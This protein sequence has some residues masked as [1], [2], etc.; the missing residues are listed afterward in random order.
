MWVRGRVRCVDMRAVV[1]LGS[2]HIDDKCATTGRRQHP[3]GSPVRSQRAE[4]IPKQLTSSHIGVG[5][6]QRGFTSLPARHAPEEAS[7]TRP[8][9][10][11]M[12]VMSP[13]TC[14]E[15]GAAWEHR[16][17]A[18]TTT[19]HAPTVKACAPRAATRCCA[20]AM[21]VSATLGCT[22]SSHDLVYHVPQLPHRFSTD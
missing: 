5:D 10:D 1:A 18:A 2:I 15:P 12:P 21:A 4:H 11:G 9:S 14:V 8:P 16:T 22:D 3:C 6:F 13:A 7:T 19:N 17:R 20:R